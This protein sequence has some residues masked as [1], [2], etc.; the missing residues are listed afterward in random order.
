MR[1]M[2]KLVPDWRPFWVPLIVVMGA[3]VL[4]TALVP[5]GQNVSRVISPHDVTV[6]PVSYLGRSAL[7]VELTAP[8]QTRVRESGATNHPA[9]AIFDTSF[10]DGVI[11][12]DLAGEVIGNGRPDARGFVGLA[13][14]SEADTSKY[15]GRSH[16]AVQRLDATITELTRPCFCAPQPDTHFEQGPRWL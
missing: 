10:V 2:S 16:G 5:A 12:A 9:L 6:T 1:A 3:V 15:E 11:E 13:F 4:T 8:M 7:K 14:H